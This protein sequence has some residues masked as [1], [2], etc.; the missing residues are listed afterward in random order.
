MQLQSNMSLQISC[1]AT[2]TPDWGG[3]KSTRQI[4]V[5]LPCIC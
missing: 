4:Q 1:W 3:C 2:V 5:R